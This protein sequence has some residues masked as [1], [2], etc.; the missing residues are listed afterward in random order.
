MSRIIAKAPGKIVLSGEYAVLDGAP[1]IVAAVDRYAIAAIAASGD[2]WS[3]VSAPGY[4]DRV[5]RF[6]IAAEGVDWLEGR[7]EF[8]LFSC[9]W[10]AA[11][12]QPAGNVSITLDTRAFHDDLSGQK[13]GLGSSAALASALACA[14]IAWSEGEQPPAD[15][16]QRAHR[17]FQHGSGS[18]LD[19]A[20]S[21]LGGVINYRMEGFTSVPLSWPRGLQYAVLWS[22]V[23]AD[24]RTRIERMSEHGRSM[25]RDRLGDV[26]G[27]IAA[28]WST[29]DAATILEQYPA[30]VEQLAAFSDELGL[31]IFSAGH[32][33]LAA[34]AHEHGLVYKPCGAGGGDIGIVLGADA[35]AIDDFVAG[36]DGHS[37]LD[38]ELGA[39]AVPVEKRD[40]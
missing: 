30:Y 20:A 21:M 5:G 14:L 26:S 1:A 18:G 40:A 2:D 24:T 39:D 4:T 35:A 13:V 22:G 31:G 36:A 29:G 17:E 37:R 11:G 27:A 23:S 10:Q 33:V 19:V 9:V 12:V 6:R 34:R 16:A 7:D 38:V 3:S 25:T 15:V 32:D 8:C 28:A